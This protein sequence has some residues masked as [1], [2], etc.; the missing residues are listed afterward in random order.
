MAHQV[1]RDINATKNLSDQAELNTSF[2]LG[3]TDVPKDTKT[4][5][6]GGTGPD[7]DGR[8]CSIGTSVIV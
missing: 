6:N 7:S 8:S 3:E 4:I 5:R 2:D 1:D